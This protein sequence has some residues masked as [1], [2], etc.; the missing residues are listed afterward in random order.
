MA[1]RS[2]RFNDKLKFKVQKEL[3]L[4]IKERWVNKRWDIFEN[5][6]LA[7][8]KFVPYVSREKNDI[9]GKP[10]LNEVGMQI[11]LSS[12]VQSEY[13]FF[14]QQFIDMLSS[15]KTELFRGLPLMKDKNK[16]LPREEEPIKMFREKDFQK[17]MTP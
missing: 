15:L 16:A 5:I 3:Q 1:R 2:L 8:Q 6:S 9:I 7:L 17:A 12:A 11:S 10:K 4:I 14:Y 13:A